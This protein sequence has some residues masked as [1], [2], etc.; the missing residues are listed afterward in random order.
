MDPTV[1]FK[2]RETP[3]IS[4]L[5]FYPPIVCSCPFLP[6]ILEVFRY[7]FF[8]LRSIL[9]FS[10][11]TPHRRFLQVY[12]SLEAWPDVCSPPPFLPLPPRSV[13]FNL[14]FF[15]KVV[16]LPPA[17]S[18]HFSQGQSSSLK[19]VCGLTQRAS[20]PLGFSRRL[21]VCSPPLHPPIGISFVSVLYN[22][23]PPSEVSES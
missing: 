10:S 21:F 2:S 17:P 11:F 7:H 4:T 14:S 22:L 13:R 19:F 18:G 8:F 9:L 16:P 20:I 3:K 1:L 5:W 12:F 15:S 23:L 6:P